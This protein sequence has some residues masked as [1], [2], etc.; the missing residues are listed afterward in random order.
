MSGQGL[1]TGYWID[2]GH[3]FTTEGY[4]TRFWLDGIHFFAPNGGYTGYWLAGNHIYGP[5]G[6][7][8]CWIDDKSRVEEWRGGS[9]LRFH[10]PLIEPG[11]AVG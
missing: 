9:R 5:D 1:V 10:S 3:I 2:D 11:L 6:Y 4:Y 7:T 8:N